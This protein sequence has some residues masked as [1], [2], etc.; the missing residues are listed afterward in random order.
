MAVRH[1]ALGI[2]EN[3]RYQG[4]LDIWNLYGIVR[5]RGFL[6]QGGTWWFII[7]IIMISL[8]NYCVLTAGWFWSLWQYPFEVE[9]PLWCKWRWLGVV[10]L[11]SE[12]QLISNRVHI[13]YFIFDLWVVVVLCPWP[14]YNR[15]IDLNLWKII[16]G[17]DFSCKEHR[18]KILSSRSV[19][20]ASTRETCSRSTEDY[21][22]EGTL[23]GT[24]TEESR[25]FRRL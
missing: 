9:A 14:R 3:Y 7:I 1:F 18:Q 15:L 22:C 20:L 16:I 21:V 17:I 19:F 13:L 12:C 24:R 5:F 23:P 4:C 2:T 10:E 8:S 6:H 25:P 11:E